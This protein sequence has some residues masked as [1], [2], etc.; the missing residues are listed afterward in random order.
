MGVSK[1]KLLLVVVLLA[2]AV[3]TFAN[4][5]DIDFAGGQ[6]GTVVVK[7]GNATGTNLPIT[8]M[9]IN[10]SMWGF[11][12]NYAV[13]GG[14]LDF[15]TQA[16]TLS[17]TGSVVVGGKTV[18][19]TLVSG[20]GLAGDFT[21]TKATGGGYVITATDAPDSKDPQLL[22]DIG[23]PTNLP[24]TLSGFDITTSNQLTQPCTLKNGKKGTCTIPNTWGGLSTDLRNT[25][26]TPEPVSMLLMGTFFSLAGGLLSRKKRA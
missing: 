14:V 8:L 20:T 5:I 1:I 22:Y 24:F 11:D 18:T 6:G 17:I 12:G 9:T 10:G 2:F 25:A 16:G 7:T 3:P 4:S 19:G 15:N 13:T 21:V 23:E 26:T